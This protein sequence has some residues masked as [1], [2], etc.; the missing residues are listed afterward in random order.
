MPSKKILEFL[1]KVQDGVAIDDECL[2][3]LQVGNKGTLQ[4]VGENET[5]VAVVTDGLFQSV[6]ISDDEWEDV[7]SL[8]DEVIALIVSQR[9][10]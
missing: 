1:R 10:R 7:D 2:V 3:S 4:P 8:A 9:K 5:R 6:T